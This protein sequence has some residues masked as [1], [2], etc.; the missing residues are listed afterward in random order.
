MHWDRFGDATAALDVLHEMAAAGL[1]ADEA[2]AELLARIRNHLHG[3]TWGAQGPF[4][5]AVMEA[6]P[7]DGALTQRLEEMERYARESLSER[8]AA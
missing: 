8:D 6:P 1:Y 5:M 7:Y 2:V 4:V 3:C